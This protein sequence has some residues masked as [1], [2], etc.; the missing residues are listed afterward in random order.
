[1]SKETFIKIY[2]IV[3]HFLINKYI[4]INLIRILKI[5]FIKYENLINFKN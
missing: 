3:L 5:G 1:M 4:F 2:L